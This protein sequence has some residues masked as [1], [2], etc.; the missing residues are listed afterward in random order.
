[1][2]RQTR[3]TIRLAACG[4]LALLAGCIQDPP[5]P[6]AR[7]AQQTIVFY[8]Q[9]ASSAADE[10]TTEL[11]RETLRD[12][13]QSGLEC[14]GDEIDGFVVHANTRGKAGRVR[15]R[16]TLPPLGDT[17]A[18]PTIV[19]AKRV[20]EHRRGMDTIRKEGA[21]ELGSL[22]TARVSGPL[23][24]QTDLVGTLEV[25]SDE[26][27]GAGAANPLPVR[28]V[29]LSDMHE[30]LSRP[31]RR[32]FD[33]RPP[34]TIEQAEAWADADAALLNQMQIDRARMGRVHVRVLMGNL[35]NKDHAGSEIRRY[36]ERLFQHA[37]VGK[38]EYN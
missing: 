16:N 9:S 32:D 34:R 14:P 33:A 17:L 19:R 28:V 13:V 12:V 37:G 15:V 31:P 3:T 24:A 25:I 2:H 26:I 36:W 35:A 30:S 11:F 5:R 23:G 22:M 29:Y 20:A 27:G 1:M 10:A 4:T 18:M 7:P 38:V 6:C 8:D 21:A